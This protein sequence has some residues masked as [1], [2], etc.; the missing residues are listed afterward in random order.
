M[1]GPP[2][3][4]GVAEVT[5]P[6]STF[7]GVHALM[8]RGET[9]DDQVATQHDVD[10]TH[11]NEL[12]VRWFGFKDECALGIEA[13]NVTLLSVQPAAST[14]SML[15][16]TGLTANTT[17]GSIPLDD[18][19]LWWTVLNTTGVARGVSSAREIIFELNEP[20]LYRVQVCGTAVTGLTACS[21]SDG[22]YFDVTP[23]SPGI[24]CIE[25][26]PRTWCTGESASDIATLAADD[27]ARARV[28]WTG[29]IDEESK[30]AGFHWAIGT[31]VGLDDIQPWSNLGWRSTAT[32][33]FMMFPNNATSRTM[34]ITLI[35]VNQVGLER[36]ITVAFIVDESPPV[37]TDD[38]V[39][40]GSPLPHHIQYDSVRYT[41]T[42]MPIAIINASRVMDGESS[43]VDLELCLY[44][45]EDSVSSQAL[46][47]CFLHTIQNR[48]SELNHAHAVLARSCAL[49]K[50]F[51][52]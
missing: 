42:T 22:S 21:T 10:Y 23:P 29:F 26:L 34:F 5:Q 39:Q 3:A 44:N 11:K 32:F 36:N 6:S 41:S 24:V 7:F 9:D 52:S 37:F 35:C 45:L 14:S 4:G 15:N 27:V 18:S 2:I 13:Y 25:V 19:R 8:L 47:L 40:L 17:Y 20:G 30:V 16:D 33:N 49:D 31:R 43:I 12:R 1:C 51:R 50:C 48:P 28:R 38:V 46:A